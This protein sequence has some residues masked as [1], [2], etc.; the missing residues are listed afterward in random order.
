MSL[1]AVEEK[2]RPV[3]ASRAVH[4]AKDCRDAPASW[5]S[6]TVLQSVCDMCTAT[7][8]VVACSIVP[9]T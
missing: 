9:R 3:G 8:S 4:G 5:K 2:V 7:A 6:G 1:I